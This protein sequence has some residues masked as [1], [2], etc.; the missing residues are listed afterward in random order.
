M[1][2]FTVGGLF[3]GFAIYSVLNFLS[4]W[5]VPLIF[6]GAGVITLIELVPRGPKMALVGVGALGIFVFLGYFVWSGAF[7]G[8]GNTYSLFLSALPASQPPPSGQ[9]L[10]ASLAWL[11]GAI[12]IGSGVMLWA[13]PKIFGEKL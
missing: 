4:Q 8:P 6:A 11:V 1:I 7:D 2:L 9:S 12:M 3:A 5:M 13:G 10:Q